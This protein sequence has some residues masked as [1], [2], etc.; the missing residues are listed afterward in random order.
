MRLQR[1]CFTATFWC[2]LVGSQAIAL[3]DLIVKQAIRFLFQT[4]HMKIFILGWKKIEGND[5]GRS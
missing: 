2:S 4:D 1:N 3:D 5:R